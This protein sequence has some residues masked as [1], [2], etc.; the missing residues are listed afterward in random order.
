MSL[1]LDLISVTSFLNSMSFL[2]NSSTVALIP[3]MAFSFECFSSC[4]ETVFWSALASNTFIE[5]CRV[6]MLVAS[7][8][9]SSSVVFSVWRHLVFQV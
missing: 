6:L 2:R 7:L 8:L 5:V 3:L 9:R 1:T 4:I